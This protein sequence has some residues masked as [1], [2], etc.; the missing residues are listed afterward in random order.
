[1]AMINMAAIIKN[2]EAERCLR[3]LLK[4]EG[5][6]LT[7]HRTHGETG[8]DIIAK[9]GKKTFHIEVIGY[10]RS[11]PT[12]ARDFFQ[13]FFQVLRFHLPPDLFSAFLAQLRV[14]V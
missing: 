5:Y 7:H 1:M 13:V 12:R 3:K 9:K 14:R 2:Q 6:R 4:A 8:V 10:N 11:G